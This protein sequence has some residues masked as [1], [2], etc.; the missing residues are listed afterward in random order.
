M[1]EG[2][3]VDE[4]WKRKARLE[5]EQDALKFGGRGAESSPPPKAGAG[6]PPEKPPR[7][8][9]PGADFAT[10]VESLAQQ[11]AMMLGSRDPYTGQTIQDLGQAQ[12]MIDMLEMLEEK[13]K[14]N[15]SKDEADHLRGVIDELRMAYVRVSA[16]PPARGPMMG[17]KPRP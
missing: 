14:G 15:L 6:A 1:S 9:R 10:L 2:K 3:R 16:P 17:N 7:P 4:D 8:D 12:I 13:T 11:A 5:R